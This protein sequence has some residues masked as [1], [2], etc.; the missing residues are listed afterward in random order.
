[1]TGIDPETLDALA[2]HHH[3][4]VRRAG[5]DPATN[6]IPVGAPRVGIY[7]S[8]RGQAIDSG[9]TELVLNRAGF[10]P[11]LRLPPQL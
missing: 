4:D 8:W 1:M 5:G 7:R 3:A 11:T 6:T 2:Q 9:W 10:W